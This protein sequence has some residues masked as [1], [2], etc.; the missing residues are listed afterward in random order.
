MFK[1][2]IL[3]VVK[4]CSFTKDGKSNPKSSDKLIEQSC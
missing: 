4:F 1:S 2:D 3:I